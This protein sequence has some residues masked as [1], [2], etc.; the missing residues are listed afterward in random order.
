MV[1]FVLI[2]LPNNLPCFPV[3]I[4]GGGYPTLLSIYL[5]YLKSDQ[6]CGIPSNN[7]TYEKMIAYVEN[8]GDYWVRLLEQ[9][10]PSTTI[11]QGG[12]KY[13]NSIFHVYKR[14]YTYGIF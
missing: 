3:T 7:Y 11:W 14:T 2:T 5:D 9:M 10:V 4:D 6:T 13:E 1:P 12:L 8:M